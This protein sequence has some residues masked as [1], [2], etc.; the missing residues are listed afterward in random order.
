MGQDPEDKTPR[1]LDCRHVRA[2]QKP[3]QPISGSSG[4][5]RRKQMIKA[6]KMCSEHGLRS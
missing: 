2:M 5:V 4:N 3:S 6:F 1:I